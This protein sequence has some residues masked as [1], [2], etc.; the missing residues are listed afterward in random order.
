MKYSETKFEEYISTCDKNNLH[1]EL[2]DTLDNLSETVADTNMIFYGPPGVGKYT[3]A[4]KSIRGGSISGL[5]YERK[6]T[7]D[8]LKGVQ[9]SFKIS[10]IH[11]EIDMELLGCNARV[12]W[13]EI[14]KAI[15]DIL[16]TRPSHK[17]II[18]CKNFHKIHNE[19]LDIFYSYMQSL[20]YKN[21]F[22]SFIILT[23]AVSFFPQAI[24]NR[25]VVIPIKRPSKSQYK[26]CLGGK[27]L[28]EIDVCKVNNI[29]SIINKNYELIDPNKVMVDRL[30]YEIEN[31]EH[32]SYLSFR[33]RIYD[34]FIYHLDLYECI[35]Y[36]LHHFIT[37]NTIDDVKLEKIQ[38]FLSK[39]LRLYNNNYRPIYHLERLV[40]Y[41]C[42]VIHEL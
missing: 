17:G 24:L 37:N 32:I 39:F 30:I 42:S 12:L 4:L 18:M 31:Y 16:S 11:F 19:L 21:I 22:I 2:I 27:L 15:L 40:F 14:Y 33:D 38:L 7:I 1:P 5:K 10:D 35:W 6:M 13:D 25:C 26:K 36:I 34:I 29:K 8:M 9:Y 41:I 23:E 28:K 3:Q 20:E